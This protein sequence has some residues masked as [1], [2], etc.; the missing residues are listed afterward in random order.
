VRAL[1][2]WWARF[3]D[4]DAWHA[5]KRY[6]DHR[7]GLLAGGI[8]YVAFLSIFP[9]LAL[10]FTIFGIVLHNQPGL[11]EDIR[12]AINDQLPGFVKS[13][14][15]PNGI[16]TLNTPSGT[17]L[18]V[19]GAVGLATLL[20]GGL[21][22]LSALRDGIRA[23]FG[24]AGSP[25]NFLLAKLRDLGV[26]VLIGIGVLLSAV[27]STA[28]GAVAGWLAGLV[29]LEGQGWLV[30][31]VGVLVQLALN[32][33]I[34]A[35]LLR[36]L[37]GVDLP[38][39]G[40]RNGAVAGGIGLTLVQ[41][42]GL[43]LVAGTLHNQSLAA[44]AIPAALLVF[45]NFISRVILLAGAWAANDLDLA[46]TEHGLSRGQR[47]KATEG[48]P[49]EPLVGVRQRTDAGLPTFGQRAADR[50]SVAAGAVLGAFGAVALGSLGRGIRRVTRRG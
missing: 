27:V 42:L 23:I 21:G 7:G 36:L 1:K 14:A 3:Q 5:W 34:V 9:I 48:P 30:T 8:S 6:G 45:L 39:P 38:W 29:G 47:L 26:L 40:L 18:S 24:V 35:L 19:T 13:A 33:A 37:S 25:D 11:I 50:T 41:V 22:W 17:A 46:T 16:I 49:E 44:V 28:A 32:A 12:N 4:T 2:A 31:V 15:N 43:R 20:W 10:A